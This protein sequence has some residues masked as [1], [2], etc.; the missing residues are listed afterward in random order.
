MAA[1]SPEREGAFE[2][3]AMMLLHMLQLG[4][5]PLFKLCGQ[6]HVQL[7][8][9]LLKLLLGLLMVLDKHLGQLLHLL[10][11]RLLGDELAFLDFKLIVRCRFADEMLVGVHFLATLACLLGLIAGLIASASDLIASVLPGLTSLVLGILP[12]LLGT[13]LRLLLRLLP[14]LL[15]GLLGAGQRGESECCC[16][17]CGGESDTFFHGGLIL[18]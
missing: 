3:L 5:L 9:N 16:Q 14:F 12:L 18:S 7:L 4:L 1:D 11:L 2:L 10:V 17:N 6:L 8:G 15:C 13:L